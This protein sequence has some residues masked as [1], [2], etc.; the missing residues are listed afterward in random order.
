MN[1]TESLNVILTH[2]QSVRF[3]L[4][5][6][7]LIKDHWYYKTTNIINMTVYYS[8]LLLNHN[9]PMSAYFWTDT[10]TAFH[11]SQKSTVPVLF[12]YIW[13][14]ETI[15]ITFYLKIHYH[16]RLIIRFTNKHKIVKR[17][18]KWNHNRNQTNRQFWNN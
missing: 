18:Q 8:F 3:K 7:K 15:M 12:A 13:F 4:K 17:L 5:L 9:N 11:P 6:R 1:L 2:F 14:F 16:Y 10:E